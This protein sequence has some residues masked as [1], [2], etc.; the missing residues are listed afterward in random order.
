M[1]EGVERQGRR[2][3]ADAGDAETDVIQLAEAAHA[4]Q[5]SGVPIGRQ[6]VAGHGNDDVAVRPGAFG[7]IGPA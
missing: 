1:G 5:D 2:G 7:D 4:A 6:A 3:R